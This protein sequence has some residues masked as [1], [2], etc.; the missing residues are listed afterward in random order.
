M[1][2][3]PSAVGR[4]GATFAVVAVSSRSWSRPHGEFRAWPEAA[5]LQSKMHHYSTSRVVLVVLLLDSFV[6][7]ADST[8]IR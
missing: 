5:Q 2:R 4:R 1:G 7:L 8:R 6:S 3:G